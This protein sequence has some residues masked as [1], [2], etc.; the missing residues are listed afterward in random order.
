MYGA[1]WRL[2][3]GPVWLKIIES[4]IL[5]AAVVYCLFFFV[6]PWVSTLLPEPGSTVGE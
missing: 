2:L 4:L 1:I 5:V 6:Y 3:P